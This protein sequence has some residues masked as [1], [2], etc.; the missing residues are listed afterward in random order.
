MFHLSFPWISYRWKIP[1]FLGE[2][3]S[4][5]LDLQHKDQTLFQF[6][7]ENNNSQYNTCISW[8]NLDKHH[9]YSLNFQF[10]LWE[11]L[12][13]Y[14]PLSKRIKADKA[15]EL[16]ENR[17]EIIGQSSDSEA[18]SNWIVELERRNWVMSATIVKYAAVTSRTSDFKIEIILDDD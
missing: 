3:S 12:V 6:P 5:Y 9:L 16:K 11:S 15:I 1:R 18:F 8:L 2:C 4:I 17:I 10:V 14:Q 7:Y 13:N